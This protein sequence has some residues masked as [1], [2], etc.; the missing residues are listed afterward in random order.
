VYAHEV[1]VEADGSRLVDRFDLTVGR[2]DWVT[3]VGPNGAGKTTLLRALAGLTRASG[4]IE[5]FGTPLARLSARERARAIALVPQVPSIPEGVTVAHYVLLGRTAHLRGLAGESAR[6]LGVVA[7]ALTQLDLGDVA[8]RSL[9]TL[10]GGERQRAVLAR[11]LAQE[12]SL[13][14]LDEPTTALDIGHQ[15]EILELVDG[16]RRRLG[17]TVVSTTHDLTLTAQYCDHLILME[18]GRAAISGPPVQ[19]LTSTQLR[20]Y[21]GAR[22][23]V[24]RHNGTLVVV[25]MRDQ[26]SPGEEPT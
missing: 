23:D 19:V 4:R 2:G 22:V 3:V 26:P 10:S 17:L 14:F 8:H 5:L 20:R 13:L 21:Y 15:Q 18:R 12:A 6:D 9:G 1:M 16:L 7:D 11:G 25:P 24:I